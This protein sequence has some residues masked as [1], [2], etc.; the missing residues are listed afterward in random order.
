MIDVE[1]YLARI[2]GHEGGYVS[3]P[4]NEDPG[5]ETK[6]GISK[7]SYPNLDIKALTLADAAEIYKRDYIAPFESLSLQPGL[8]FQLIDFAIHSS[9]QTAIKCLQFELGVAHDGL[10]GPRTKAVVHSKT[11]SDLVMLITAAR[12]DYM[13]DLKNWPYNSRGWTKRIAKNL[14]YGAVDTD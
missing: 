3:R 7:R 6:W 12:L 2:Y 9:V 4:L 10:I 8:V 1:N 14:R 13:S 5:S 11:D